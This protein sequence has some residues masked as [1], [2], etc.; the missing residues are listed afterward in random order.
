MFK[1]KW[2]S[3]RLLF[4]PFKL[5]E[6]QVA[7]NIFSANSH[8]V[9]VDPTFREWPLSEYESLINKDL[10][11]KDLSTPQAFI[12]R[13]IV[14]K[15]GD[16]VGYLQLE[17]NAPANEQC[18]I[19]MLVLSPNKQGLGYGTEI[20]RSIVDLLSTYDRFNLLQLNVYA[21][22]K[23]SF[24]FWYNGGF[25]KIVAFEKEHENGREYNCLVLSRMI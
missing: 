11:P 17:L 21:E 6:A 14:E 10:E 23:D 7:K 24:R 3:E 9:N 4:E 12:L 16:V 25:N 8:L 19:P 1:E 13:K 2:E 5:N 15:E 20:L 22:N 18:W